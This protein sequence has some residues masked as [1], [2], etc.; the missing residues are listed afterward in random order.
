MTVEQKNEKSRKRREVSQRNKGPP[1]QPEAS[2]GDE[3]VKFLIVIIP[4]CTLYS[5][6]FVLVVA[7]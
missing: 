4:T 7:G 2:R 6:R 1:I 5:L 3:K